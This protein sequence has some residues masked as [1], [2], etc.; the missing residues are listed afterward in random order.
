[1]RDF[2]GVT[3]FDHKQ[4]T[5]WP[6]EWCD[7]TSFEVMNC[8]DETSM[9]TTYINSRLFRRTFTCPNK[10]ENYEENIYGPYVADM[11]TAAHYIKTDAQRLYQMP[12]F[13]Q[14]NENEG[15]DADIAPSAEAVEKYLALLDEI[16]TA[17][18]SIYSLNLSM[19]DEEYLCRLQRDAAILSYF[20][21][22]ILVDV[23]KKILI[24]LSFGSD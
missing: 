16:I 9:I 8:C 2:D 10:Y 3:E 23:N 11:I 21:G 12:E 6:Y 13:I 18:T 7:A 15:D 17:E 5:L 4:V 1:M 14:K 22:F 24:D 20:Y 19:S